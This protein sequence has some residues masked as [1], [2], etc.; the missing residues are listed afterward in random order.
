MLLWFKRTLV[1][2]MAGAALGFV[3]WCL[4]GKRLTAMFFGTPGGSFSCQTDVSNALDRFVSM[5]LYSA[6]AGA[7]VAFL[8]AL[9]VRRW[10]AKS[11]A[12]A[13]PAVAAGPVP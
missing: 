6:I 1:E 5:Q 10:W 12:K 7:L 11:H 2:L 13:A 3:A 8:A 9:L 4:M